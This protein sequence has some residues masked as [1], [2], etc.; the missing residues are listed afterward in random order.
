MITAIIIN[1]HDHLLTAR[2]A[3]SV[4]ADQPDA[5]IIIVDNSVDPAEAQALRET[6]PPQAELLIAP[7]NLGFG[8]GCNLGFSYARHDWIFLL[9]PDAFVLAG[10][11]TLLVA[12]L[13]QNQRVGAVAPLAYWDQDRQWLL[14]PGQ[15]PLPATELGMQLALRSSLFGG[16]VSQG[17]RR[18]ALRCL[19][20]GAPVRQ[21]MLSGGHML[22]RRSAVEAAGG[23][24]D[25]TF[26]MY[27]EDADLCVRLQKKGFTLYLLPTASVVHEWHASPAKA[28][29][30]Q[31]SL[32]QYFTK[33]FPDSRLLAWRNAL[34]HSGR[35]P[36][37]PECRHLG[38]C[39]DP[40]A[41]SL[42][43]CLESGQMAELSLNP[44]FIP[45]IYYL[46]NNNCFKINDLL[47]RRL[48]PGSY[49]VRIT[50]LNSRQTLSV[51]WQKS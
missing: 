25:A 11:I 10:C 30:S 13:Q 19:T 34:E 33:H 49:W 18:W 29:H 44:L 27:C 37:L 2:A 42:P 46:G 38:V 7:H 22:L 28:G 51:S 14:P 21:R 50:G 45:A 4:L 17:F 23:L 16:W 6:L 26:F 5:Q 12:F 36:C 35:G 47:W 24:F 20:S 39:I 3:A 40:A 15:L 41:L 31:V 32:Q 8:N 48:G 9:N 43:D 1:Y